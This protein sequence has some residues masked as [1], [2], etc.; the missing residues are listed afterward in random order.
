M[1]SSERCPWRD[2]IVDAPPVCHLS[3]RESEILNLLLSGDRVKMIARDLFISP[4]TVRNHLKS[5]FRKFDVSSQTELIELFAHEK[6]RD[7]I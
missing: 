5:I 4:N 7:A 2:G 3:K 1:I 6:K